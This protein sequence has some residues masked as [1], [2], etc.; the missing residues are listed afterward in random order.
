MFLG[1]DKNAAMS[2]R[3]H[4]AVKWFNNKKGYGFITT[5]KGQDIFAHFSEIQGEGFKSLR[6]GDTVEFEIA[7][8]PKGEFAKAIMKTT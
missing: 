7:T 3:E 6:E 1:D 5:E 2:A 4:G 8:G